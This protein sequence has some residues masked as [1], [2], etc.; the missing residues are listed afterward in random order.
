M[1]EA[2]INTFL[3]VLGLNFF[4]FAVVIGVNW[5]FKHRQAVYLGLSAIF[6]SLVGSI[7]YLGFVFHTQGFWP[8]WFLVLA[9]LVGLVW[10]VWEY[11]FITI[12]AD[13]PS[14]GVVT[15]WGERNIKTK[16]T[17]KS[18]KPT[19]EVE[20]VGEGLKLHAPY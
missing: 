6:I 11:F 18:K 12:P 19:G 1:F 9:S 8:I 7:I 2:F 14:I 17:K 3:V 10:V 16:K 4:I 20:Y 13:P 5:A 15:V